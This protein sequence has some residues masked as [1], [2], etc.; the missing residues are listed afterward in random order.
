MATVTVDI[1]IRKEN[2]IKGRQQ[3]VIENLLAYSQR[4][5][6]FLFI[7]NGKNSSSERVR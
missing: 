2:K 7:Y 4:I 1:I 5:H 6:E 3:Y